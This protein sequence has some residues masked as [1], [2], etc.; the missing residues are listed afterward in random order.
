MRFSRISGIA[1]IGFATTIVTVNLVL[2]PAGLP[3][4]GAAPAEVNAFFSAK[5]ALVGLGSALT[6]A[7]WVLATVFGAGA[8]AALWTSERERGEAW[9]LVGFTGV[10]LQNVTFAAVI[11]TRLALSRTATDAPAGTPGLWAW[12]DGIF[13]LN[14]TFLAIALVGLSVAGLR[15]RFIRPWHGALGFVAAA[16]QFASACLAFW[17]MKEQGPLGLIGLAGWL[18]W[19]AWI[20]VYGIRLV[21]AA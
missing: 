19:V 13:T 7:A 6:P 8:V 4:T 1:A 11:A 12:H 21:R 9:S 2:T 14:A 15:A 5:G 18:L 3:L 10:A 16:L 17:I 20:V